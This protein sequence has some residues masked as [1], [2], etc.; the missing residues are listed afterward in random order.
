MKISYPLPNKFL[1]YFPPPK[2]QIPWCSVDASDFPFS[3]KVFKHYFGRKDYILN[4]LTTQLY[5]AIYLIWKILEIIKTEREGFEPSTKVTS[6]NS[7]AGSRFPPL[8]PLSSSYTL[9]IFMQTFKIFYLIEM[10]NQ[11]E[12]SVIYF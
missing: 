11:L 12:L 6:C 5:S 1:L 10:S 9:S 8:S 2:H 4:E 3:A 7:F